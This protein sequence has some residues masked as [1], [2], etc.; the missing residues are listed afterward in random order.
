MKN[1]FEWAP[2]QLKGAKSSKSAYAMKM[3]QKAELRK[4]QDGV[5]APKLT[6]TSR[7]EA[8]K[9]NTRDFN[10]PATSSAISF[11]LSLLHTNL[12]KAKLGG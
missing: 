6:C 10:D 1:I 4:V 7:Y 11:A 8:L 3:E 12:K 9:S 5:N 2:S